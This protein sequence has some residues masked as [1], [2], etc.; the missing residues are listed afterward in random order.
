[1]LWVGTAIAAQAQSEK[2]TVEGKITTE[3]KPLA[4]VSVG[5]PGTPHG[6]TTDA[7]GRY[8]ISHLP[9]GTYELRAS[10]TGYSGF[11]TS[12]TLSAGQPAL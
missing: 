1:M 3:G 2:G 10:F 12:V 8:S 6:T 9:F 4:F 7:D 11:R 5:L